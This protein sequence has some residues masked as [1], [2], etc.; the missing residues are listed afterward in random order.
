MNATTKTETARA[1]DLRSFLAATARGY[2]SAMSNPQGAADDLLAARAIN[3]HQVVHQCV[4][5]VGIAAN[6]GGGGT[7]A[8]LAHEYFVTQPLRGLDFSRGTRQA[9]LDIGMAAHGAPS[10]APGLFRYVTALGSHS[11][12]SLLQGPDLD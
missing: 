5:L 10:L 7:G 1:A 11:A 2:R 6:F 3:H 4:V 12:P 9:N 8:P